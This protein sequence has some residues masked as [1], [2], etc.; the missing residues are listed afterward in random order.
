[1]KKIISLTLVL[2]CFLTISLSLSSQTI[3]IDVDDRQD[4][5]I[6]T[7]GG[8]QLAQCIDPSNDVCTLSFNQH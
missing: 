4:R 7:E 1:M 6:P 3:F 8:G 2:L 5:F